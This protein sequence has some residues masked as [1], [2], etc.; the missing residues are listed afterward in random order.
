MKRTLVLVLCALFAVTG[1]FAQKKY[2]VGDY[3]PSGGIVFYAESGNYV[4]CDVRIYGPS[5]W[6]DAMSDATR[7]GNW[8]LPTKAELSAIYK[9]L[10]KQ[11]L[12]DFGDRGYWTS[13]DSANIDGTKWY[14]NFK[15]GYA[16]SKDP[17]EK[18]WYVK[19]RSFRS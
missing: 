7:S 10:K 3:G 5:S 17:Q 4:E 19:V 8:R 16:G 6:N 11:G 15:N 2:N 9:T 1:L 14:Y 18:Y 13:E 12:M